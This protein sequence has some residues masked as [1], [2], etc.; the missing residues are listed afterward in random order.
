MRPALRR[1]PDGRPAVLAQLVGPRARLP[2]AGRPLPGTARAAGADR[3]QNRLPELVIL[4]VR[5]TLADALL[6]AALA[7]LYLGS[8]IVLQF[9][10]VTATERGQSPAATVASTLLIPARAELLRARIQRGIDRRFY[11][12][13][14]DTARTLAA[15]GTALRGEV[16]T[17]LE[18]LE[19]GLVGVLQA[20]LEPESIWL[21]LR[22]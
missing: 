20:P 11:R 8:V 22:S 19:T 7:M 2:A 16:G 1:P 4:L 18:D 3:P 13:R 6:T 5:P 17:D 14:Y 15:Y 9:V 21:W 12:Q 10:L